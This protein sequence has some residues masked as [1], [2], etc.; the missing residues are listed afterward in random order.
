[1]CPLLFCSLRSKRRRLARGLQ[2]VPLSA[3]AA[4]QRPSFQSRR[5]TKRLLAAVCGRQLAERDGRTGTNRTSGFRRRGWL[6]QPLPHFVF[7]PGVS[8][9]FWIGDAH[10]LCPFSLGAS[11]TCL[12]CGWQLWCP[13]GRLDGQTYRQH[14]SASLFGNLRPPSQGEG[15]TLGER[16]E[17]SGKGR[18]GFNGSV[19]APAAPNHLQP[20]ASSSI[21]TSLFPANAS[22]TH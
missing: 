3:A 13:A 11:A 8:W 16:G 10:A 4:Q 2:P 22:A 19:G 7:F 1:M 6:A 18:A 14:V 9:E 12:H 21:S 17:R 20:Q 15:K 5:E